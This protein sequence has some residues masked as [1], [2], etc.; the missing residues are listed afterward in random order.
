MS[1]AWRSWARRTVARALALAG[2][3][4]GLR[5]LTYHRVNDDHP[6]DRLTVPVQAFRAQMEA[7]VAERRPVVSLRSM[8]PGLRGTA[9]IAEG[10][11]ALTFDDGYEDNFRHALPVLERLGLPAT[12]F[13]ATGLV[14][15]AGTL[16]RYRGCCGKD[17][18][19]G[20]EQVRE[21]RSRGHEIGGHGRMHLEL[22]RLPG[23]EARAELEGSAADG[24]DRVDF[25][26][27][28][29]LRSVEVQGT[30]RHD[31]EPGLELEGHAP[32]VRS[33]DDRRERRGLV[34]QR[35]VAV[36]P[37]Q[38]ESADLPHHRYVSPGRTEGRS[39]LRE[40]LRHGVRAG[41]RGE[42]HGAR[43]HREGF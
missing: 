34:F 4:P 39:D 31:F 38:V 16:D 42:R 30:A 9:P 43:Q 1:S 2:A 24:F 5:I 22:A 33:E 32:K 18:M 10:A 6:A 15:T 41:R 12:F 14:G 3:E 28:F 13:I 27:E 11:V 40:E 25:D 20:W 29:P 7:L 37:A 23:D 35:E 21:L 17:G 8:L 36:P 19:L 26:L